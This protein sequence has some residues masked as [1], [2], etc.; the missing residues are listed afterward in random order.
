MSKCEKSI[1]NFLQEKNI[2]FE[3]QKTF[4]GLNGVNGGLLSYDFFLPDYNLLI[5]FQ[6]E[7]H[8]HPVDFNGIG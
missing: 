8:E 6:G 4:K 7:Q 1:L 5:E 2:K 3:C